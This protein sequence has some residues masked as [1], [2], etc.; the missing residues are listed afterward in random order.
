VLTFQ[1]DCAVWI[2]LTWI[3]RP[4][5]G[6]VA[7]VAALVDGRVGRHLA[8]GVVVPGLGDLERAGAGVDIDALRRG[9]TPDIVHD[10]ELALRGVDAVEPAAQLVGLR[11][12]R[13]GDRDHRGREYDRGCAERREQ[14]EP[15]GRSGKLPP[16]ATP[17]PS[18]ARPSIGQLRGIGVARMGSRLLVGV[19]QYD[20][21][22][23]RCPFLP[24]QPRRRRCKV[25]G[26]AARPSGG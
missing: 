23:T 4:V 16:R 18:A 6:A 9:G 13:R 8:V 22:A 17:R 10:D 20:H 25:W 26:R 19:Y 2:W 24:R 1:L 3:G 5:A 14:P 21:P 12:G 7:P 15:S 11:A